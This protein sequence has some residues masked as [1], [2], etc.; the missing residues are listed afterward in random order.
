MSLVYDFDIVVAKQ[1]QG[2]T[3]GYLLTK[4][5]LGEAKDCEICRGC[6]LH[7]V[8]PVM[9]GMLER[10]FEFEIDDYDDEPKPGVFVPCI[11]RK[12]W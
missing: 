8:N 2:G 11:M 1:Y 4:A 12:T 7:V 3:L 5:S 10:L 6:R 9:A